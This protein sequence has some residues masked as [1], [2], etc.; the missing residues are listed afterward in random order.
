MVRCP[1]ST[2][3]SPPPDTPG[4]RLSKF[5]NTELFD[6]LRALHADEFAYLQKRLK[7]T[8]DEWD[9]SWWRRCLE[10]IVEYVK[11][12]VETWYKCGWYVVF[13]PPSEFCC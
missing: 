5:V 11:F 7:G 4:S 1:P 2:P 10:I 6:E 12:V 9:K 8:L 13:F 3:S